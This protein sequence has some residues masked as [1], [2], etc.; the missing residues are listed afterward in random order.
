MIK[1]AAHFVAKLLLII[2]LGV[3][4]PGW[5]ELSQQMSKLRLRLS[6]ARAPAFQSHATIPRVAGPGHVT[7]VPAPAIVP[8]A[9]CVLQS[10]PSGRVSA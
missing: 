6:A 4:V 8:V 9:A 7:L 2:I 1:A 10:P 5:A 3:A